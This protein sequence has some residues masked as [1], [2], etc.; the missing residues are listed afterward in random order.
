MIQNDP[1]FELDG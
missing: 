1:L